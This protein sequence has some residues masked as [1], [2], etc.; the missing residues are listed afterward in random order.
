[1]ERG[2]NDRLLPGVFHL[3]EL[4]AV[5]IRA[6]DSEKTV[7]FL[8]G[9]ILEEHGPYL[10]CYTDGYVNEYLVHHLAEAVASRAGWNALIFP[11]IPLGTGGAN[12][13]GEKYVFPGTYTVRT[14]TLR[15]VF[16]DL[17][18]ELGEQGFRWI[19]VMHLHG[20]PNQNKMLDQACACFNDLYPGKMVNLAGL[21]PIGMIAVIDAELST[22]DEILAHGMDVHAGWGETGLLLAVQP[23]LVDPAYK[24]APPQRGESWEDLSRIAHAPDWPGYFSMPAQADSAYG[25]AFMDKLIERY[26]S[27]LQQI[28]DGQGDEFFPRYS[29]T[30][31]SVN[32]DIN[33]GALKEE[34]RRRQIQEEWL[35]QHGLT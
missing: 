10:P 31:S 33:Q 3:K 12:E 24:N 13:I 35:K 28:L 6:L 4:N 18:I 15:A 11:T 1:M 30:D 22:E 19:F 5:Q 16:M 21:D 34:N 23:G 17:A 8:P 27:V 25:A 29:L 9:G 7:I 26:G 2:R 20:A 14:S 32:D